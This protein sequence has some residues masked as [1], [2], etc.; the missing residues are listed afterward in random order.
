MPTDA[1]VQIAHC[2]LCVLL[3]LKK[4]L[5]YRLNYLV[6][7]FKAYRLRIRC[8]LK[9]SSHGHDNDLLK[10]PKH[11]LPQ[12]SRLEIEKK[13]LLVLSQFIKYSVWYYGNESNQKRKC[14]LFV[15][16]IY[17]FSGAGKQKL[18]F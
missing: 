4:L 18:N 3:S 7:I 8:H 12:P 13:N 2:G 17:I 15:Y 5:N 10:S 1:S 9:K 14:Q 16:K 11:L 6:T